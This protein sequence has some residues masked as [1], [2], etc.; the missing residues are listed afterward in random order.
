MDRSYTKKRYSNNLNTVTNA[1][2]VK[3]YPNINFF[4]FAIYQSPHISQ[5]L[6]LNTL[7]FIIL[8]GGPSAALSIHYQYIINKRKLPTQWSRP[9]QGYY[10]PCLSF[11]FRSFLWSK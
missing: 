3:P 8:A 7:T 10:W 11:P 4:T 9:R 1:A 5:F 6:N 2:T